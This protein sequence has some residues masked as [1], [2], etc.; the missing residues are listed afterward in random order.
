ME[1]T[2]SG[3]LAF[4]THSQSTTVD[5]AHKPRTLTYRAWVQGWCL[6]LEPPNP[7][8]PHPTFNPK[9]GVLNPDPCEPVLAVELVGLPDSEL[10]AHLR[11]GVSNSG[12]LPRSFIL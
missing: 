9:A 2:S 10:Q 12:L 3:T 11:S 5:D 6:K 4:E 8:P 1:S 7:K